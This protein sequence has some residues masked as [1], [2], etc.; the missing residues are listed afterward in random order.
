MKK[1]YIF[2]GLAL[3]LSVFACTIPTSI[4]ITG[5]PK[6]KIAADISKMFESMI[7]D[8]FSGAEEVDGFKMLN[9]TKG[10]TIGGGVYRTFLV[11]M[12][13]VNDTFNFEFGQGINI[14]VNALGE[15][16]L[17]RDIPL[18]NAG[19][20]EPIKLD[21]SSL[22]DYLEG[23][24]FD[25]NEV[26]AALYISGSPLLSKLEIDLKFSGTSMF[27]NSSLNLGASGITLDPATGG[28]A[29]DGL[30]T[31]KDGQPIGNAIANFASLM[32]SKDEKEVTYDVKIPMGTTI[33]SQWLGAQNVNVV[34]ELAI[35]IPLYFEAVNNPSELKFPD[36][37]SGVGSFI[38][39]IAEVVD[40][41][42]LV[43][44]MNQN[45]FA[46]GTLT[47]KDNDN[48]IEID[49]KL[50]STSLEIEIK[51]EVLE[52]IIEVN[53]EEGNSF[54]PDFAI[55]FDNGEH[56]GIPKGLTTTIAL[57]AEL[58]YNVEF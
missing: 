40:N 13:L 12:D 36:L 26:K 6:V 58:H 4:E 24:K 10:T 27:G 16:E 46:E 31:I 37:M 48:D 28:Y 21:F 8:A 23:F 55:V 3:A 7:G 29:G 44:E 47:V 49:T 11:R 17:D 50:T 35:W 9:C 34:I 5:T 32:N 1:V 38:D 33:D 54:N 42:K 19:D 25:D 20:N 14:I 57:E 22:T 15:Y 2:A 45:P 52:R 39:T 53:A 56:L 41:L 43:I 30:P 18:V 51:K